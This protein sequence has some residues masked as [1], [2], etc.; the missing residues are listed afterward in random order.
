MNP[1][2]NIA[3]VCFARNGLA[4]VTMGVCKEGL[5]RVGLLGIALIGGGFGFG[6]VG[7]VAGEFEEEEEWIVFSSFDLLSVET[8]L[9]IDEFGTLFSH[10]LSELLAEELRLTGEQSLEKLELSPV[11]GEDVAERF[12]GEDDRFDNGEGKTGR[13]R[14]SLTRLFKVL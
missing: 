8:P 14:F 4:Y 5:K 12:D 6:L 9:D 10:S 1:F 11:I 13:N 2:G 3:G 7:P